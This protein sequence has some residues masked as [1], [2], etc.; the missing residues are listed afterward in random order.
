MK[1]KK[2]TDET[3]NRKNR[4][5]EKQTKRK[6]DTG[7]TVTDED[8][9]KPT[10]A[11]NQFEPTGSSLQKRHTKQHGGHSSIMGRVKRE[12]ARGDKKSLR[13]LSRQL[14]NARWSAIRH[15]TNFELP[16]ASTAKLHLNLELHTP[17]VTVCFF[18]QSQC[19]IST[20][21]NAR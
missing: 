2:K 3:K 6:T 21:H 18:N 1:R 15:V 20:N 19:T 17:G 12:R 16:R 14:K 13:T 4:R 8:F 10:S 7:L 11:Q 5:K 9:E